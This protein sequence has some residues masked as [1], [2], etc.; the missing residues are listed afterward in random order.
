VED[1]SQELLAFC[2]GHGVEAAGDVMGEAVDIA[3]E[4]G[5]GEG[6]VVGEPVGGLELREEMAVA[7]EGHIDGGV[8]HPGLDGFW[9]DR[10]RR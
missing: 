10:R 4:V 8:S 1:G 5:L 3:F 7:V 2:E 6:V 9:D